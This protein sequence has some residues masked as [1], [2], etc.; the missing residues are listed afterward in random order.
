MSVDRFVHAS[1]SLQCLGY[2]EVI[3]CCVAM[4]GVMDLLRN[5]IRNWQS[6]IGPGYKALRRRRA[7][8]YIDVEGSHP[9]I[10]PGEDSASSGIAQ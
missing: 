8:L 2:G 9:D 6:T 1:L 10:E 7:E 4:E 3:C 5:L